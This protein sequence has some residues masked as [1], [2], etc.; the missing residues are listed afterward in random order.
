MNARRKLVLVDG[1]GYLYRAFHALPPLQ[2]SRGE[3]TGA[4]LGVVN[5]LNKLCREESPELIAVVFDAPG[6]TF[7]DELFEEYKA[8]RTPMPDDLRSQLQPLLDCVEAMGLPMLRV[9][10]V[11]ADDVIGTLAQQAAAQGY[12]VLISTGDKDMAQIVNERIVLV[13]TMTGSRLDR[14]G[15][16][17]KFDVY[18]EQIVDY[19]ALVGDTSDNI[20]GIPKVGPKT[21]AKWLGEFGTLDKVV[22]NAAS[23][24]GKVG[25]NLRAGMKDLELSRKLATLDCNVKLDQPFETLRVGEPNR[26]RLRELFT[27]MEFRA[28]LKQLVG[29]D[30][31]GSTPISAAPSAYATT[32]A[33][34]AP[35]PAVPRNYETVL[36]QAALE[37]W[38]AKLR[39][40][41]EMSLYV[42]TTS[43]GYMQADIVGIAF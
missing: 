14:A 7:R 15:V 35:P 2:N 33:A 29:D 42:A 4:V 32:D 43:S 18:P 25:E 40:S 3:P 30:A 41:E 37:Q 9:D 31:G 23:I 5:M 34:T 8:T 17:A 28:L 20:P 1:S 36:T 26:E 12:D 11:E 10:G 6:R 27:R 24:A 22:E 21:A 16:K 13:N 39:A 19:L 38:L